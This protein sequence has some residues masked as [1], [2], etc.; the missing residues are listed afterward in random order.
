LAQ[1]LRLALDAL[2]RLDR[3]ARLSNVMKLDRDE[4]VSAHGDDAA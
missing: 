2:V 3:E 4:R 1:D